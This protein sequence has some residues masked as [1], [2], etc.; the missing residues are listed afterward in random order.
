MTGEPQPRTS[1]AG[2]LL[3]V[4]FAGFEVVQAV[5][6]HDPTL[7]FGTWLALTAALVMAMRMPATRAEFARRDRLRTGVLAAE[8]SWGALAVAAAVVALVAGRPFT[9]VWAGAAVV[10]ALLTPVAVLAGP[11]PAA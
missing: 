8:A 3:L 4:L 2:T 10:A 9:W 1:N 7:L 5:A 6:Q 11:G